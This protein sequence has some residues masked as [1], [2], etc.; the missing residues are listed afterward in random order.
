[1]DDIQ[2]GSAFR[3]LRI[4]RGLRQS[5]VAQLAGV[6]RSAVS[7]LER[8][9]LDELPLGAIRL[10]AA[11][12]DARF[13]VVPR[14]RGGDLGRLINERH[15]AM[16]DEIAGLFGSLPAWIADPEVSFSIYGERG[17]IDIL[18]WHAGRRML[19]VIELKTEIV[20]VND[21]MGGVDRKRRLARDIARERGWD[22]VAVSVWV[23]V[24]EGRTNRRRVE[25]H[26]AV[27]RAK[28][29]DDGRTVRTSLADP[30]AAIAALSFVSPARRGAQARGL[31][32][33]RR[34]RAGGTKRISR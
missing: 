14:W 26:V 29:P 16:H 10:I 15:A 3:H 1:M 5:D 33:V 9:R 7:R 22:P 2:I 11:A 24:A 27:L 19:L 31:A 12:Y 8:G 30:E 17:V 13:E 23:A 4:R 6:S 21:L 34:V 32:T 28:F 18:A 20:D 25:R